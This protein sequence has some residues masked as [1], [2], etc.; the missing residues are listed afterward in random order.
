MNKLTTDY[1]YFDVNNYGDS[2]FS[3]DFYHLNIY[4]QNK[5]LLLKGLL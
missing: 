5:K 2:K 3:S 1:S 4:F